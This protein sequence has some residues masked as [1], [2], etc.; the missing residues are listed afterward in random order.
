MD[1]HPGQERIAVV[2]PQMDQGYHAAFNAA[3]LHTA[4][5]AFPGSPVSFRSFP[6]HGAVVRGILEQHAPEA[7]A[8]VEWRT[9]EPPPS[10]SVVA[11]WRYNRK[12]LQ[13]VL[14]SGERVLLTSASRLQLMQLKGLVRKGR[15]VT[16]VLHGDLDQ[17]ET[18]PP[19][20]FP[21]TLWSLARV[22]SA[23]APAGL[24][25]IVLSESIR[26]NIPPQFHA[27]DNAGVVD[28]PFYSNPIP[29]PDTP[30]DTP[31]SADHPP[32]F[33]VLGNTGSGLLFE[34]VARA[35]KQIDP[36]IRFRLAGFLENQAAVE[37]LQ[38]FVED[39]TVEMTPRATYVE[40]AS[41]LRYAL[42]L[43]E[44]GTFRLR[45]SGTFFDA[46]AFGKP[47]IY[48]T[49]PFIDGYL[50]AQDGAEQVGIR[51]DSVQEV[52]AAI[53]RAAQEDP[54]TYNARVAAILR[55]RERFT[56]Q[57]LASSLRDAMLSDR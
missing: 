39:A 57:V 3:M 2:E 48:V 5:L 35:V 19:E 7:A 45:A 28:F 31:L 14:G 21:K 29:P 13:G 4:V 25:F 17:L 43:A 42:W 34:Q 38:P 27:L 12:L 10:S 56:P 1:Q 55:L 37:R 11:R 50:S 53:L 47:L 40:R 6:R 9:A 46:L 15:R 18:P 23:P 49:N 24:H 16:V 32:I 51:C 44:P 54:A 36:A 26:R 41:S 33:G 30:P 22:L 52:P 20:G 8:Q